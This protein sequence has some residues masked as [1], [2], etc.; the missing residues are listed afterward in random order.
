MKRIIA[1]TFIATLFHLAATAQ[2][3]PITTLQKPV[4]QQVVIPPANSDIELLKQQVLE[5]QQQLKALKTE[6]AAS[7]K[8]LDYSLGQLKKNF[9]NHYHIAD[10]KRVTGFVQSGLGNANSNYKVAL[11]GYGND[12][13]TT[14]GKPVQAE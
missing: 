1:F 14:T 8:L 9:E 10:T 5:L 3:R 12:H 4:Q 13:T 7:Y 2:V 6:L 11:V